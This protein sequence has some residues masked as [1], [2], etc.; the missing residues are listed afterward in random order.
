MCIRVFFSTD[1]HPKFIHY[2]REG[3]KVWRFMKK[4]VPLPA[5]QTIE[6]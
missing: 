4:D 6:L 3:Q 2:K 5:N 1:F